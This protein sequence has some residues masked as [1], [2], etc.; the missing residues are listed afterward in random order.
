VKG[1]EDSLYV[2]HGDNDFKLPLFILINGQT[3]SAAEILSAALHFHLNAPVFG[4][5][6]YGK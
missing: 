3:A 6:S 1:A 5:Q 4:S 2:S